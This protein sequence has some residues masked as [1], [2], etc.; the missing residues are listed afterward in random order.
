VAAAIKMPPLTFKPSNISIVTDP[1]NSKKAAIE[2]CKKYYDWLN[3]NIKIDGSPQI[4][5]SS[6][7]QSSPKLKQFIAI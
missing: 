4:Y 3:G 7:L 5:H 2:S 1:H 6:F